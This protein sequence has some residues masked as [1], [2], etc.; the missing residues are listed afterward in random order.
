MG[1]EG[2][3]I[4]CDHSKDEEIA[5]LFERVLQEQGRIDLLVNNVWQNPPGY[6]VGAGNA[7]KFRFW[8]GAERLWDP[9]MKVGLRSH[10]IASVHAARIMTKQK[11]GL[12]INISSEG[13]AHY[14]F[15]L[16]YGVGKCALDRMTSDM[17]LELQDYNVAA[18]SLWPGLVKTEAT[19]ERSTYLQDMWK[20]DFAGKGNWFG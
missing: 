1:G 4:R 8:E 5:A 11:S 17:A 6:D 19:M 15:Y 2:H 20:L 16:A 18:I 10:Y 12:I 9:V 14:L 3:A 7:E 13:A